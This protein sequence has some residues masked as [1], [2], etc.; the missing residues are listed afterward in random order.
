MKK[1]FSRRVL[2][3]MYFN[4]S[5]KLLLTTF[6][7]LK[8]SGV[9]GKNEAKL[10]SLIK[11]VHDKKFFCKSF[12]PLFCNLILEEKDLKRVSF[13]KDQLV[14]DLFFALM[15][16]GFIEKKD[17]DFGEDEFLSSYFNKSVLKYSGESE[18]CDKL[19]DRIKFLNF[20]FNPKISSYDKNFKEVSKDLWVN[21][22]S[23]SLKLLSE[24]TPKIYSEIWPF[25][26][27]FGAYGVEEDMQNS[28]SFTFNIGAIYLSFIESN[29]NI[30]QGQA[31]V[32]E[33]LHSAFSILVQFDKLIVNGYDDF[34]YY[35]PVLKIKR[36][37]IKCLVALHAFI[38]VLN[39]FCEYFESVGIENLGEKKE[40]YL[41]KMFEAFYKNQYLIDTIEKY[42]KFTPKGKLF[43]KDLLNDYSIYRELVLKLE[44]EFSEISFQVKKDCENHLNEV[45]EEFEDLKY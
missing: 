27:S 39:F 40:F 12:I 14:Y 1:F 5:K 3:E 35:S 24:K 15:N 45:L 42:A 6:D 41:Y 16:E 4:Y 33:V 32:H 43:F 10:F 13:Y 8:V 44:S 34:D 37:L 38:G 26:D 9:F 2:F 25:C 17:V 20:N 7:N 23:E 36:P 22:F 31:I 30:I 29:D 21:Q 19:N 28:I 18:V 11:I